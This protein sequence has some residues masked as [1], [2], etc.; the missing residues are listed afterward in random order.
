MGDSFIDLGDGGP[1]EAGGAHNAPEVTVSELPGR[2]KKTLEDA[3]GRVR[4]RGEVGRV[5]RPKSGHAY[6]ASDTHLTLPTILRV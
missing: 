1:G 3:F 6:P 4:V 5:S 2:V